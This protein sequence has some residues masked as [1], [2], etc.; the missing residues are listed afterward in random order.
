MILPPDAISIVIPAKN[1]EGTI[2][3]IVKSVLK[4]SNDVLVRW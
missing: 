4:Y 2:A 1:E 3:D